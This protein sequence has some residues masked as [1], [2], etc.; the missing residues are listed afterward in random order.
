R[1]VTLRGG[2]LEPRKRAPFR[3]P[4]PRFELKIGEGIGVWIDARREVDPGFGRVGRNPAS[5]FERAAVIGERPLVR[6]PLYPHGHAVLALAAARA[7][8][9]DHRGA[10]RLSG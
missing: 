4:R 9:P 1:A 7:R 5:D 2:G 8:R 3:Q 10:D 6:Y